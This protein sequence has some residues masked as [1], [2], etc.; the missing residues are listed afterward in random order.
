MQSETIGQ[1]AAALSKAQGEMKPPK[2][3]RVCV[4]KYKDK[5]GNW[6]EKKYNYSDLSDL[7]ECLRAPFAKHELA[8]TQSFK[9]EGNQF[10]LVTTIMHSSGEWVDSL[11]PIAK[12]P[13][14]Q[15]QGSEITYARRY[16]LS[17]LAGVAA[18]DDDDGEA[19]QNAEPQRNEPEPP[20]EQQK[21]KDAYVEAVWA[22][23]NTTKK[24]GH[25]PAMEPPEIVHRSTMILP[26]SDPDQYVSRWQFDIDE[27]LTHRKTTETMKDKEF[28][29]ATVHVLEH[30][31]RTLDVAE[32]L[33]TTGGG[34]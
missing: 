19:A 28:E 11:Y 16:A 7:L 8:W 12:H 1:I 23:S 27:T 33:P 14:P 6:R 17:T 20:K 4:I 2:K 34:E 24:P 21:A 25:G 13:K 5:G 9:F 22:C 26:A 15:D 18:E 3:D 29:P 32:A 10:L 31:Q 30:T